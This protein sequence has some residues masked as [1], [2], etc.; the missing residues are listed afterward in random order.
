MEEIKT[1]E[2]TLSE[3]RITNDINNIRNDAT[4][5]EGEKKKMDT[6]DI[7]SSSGILI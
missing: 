3:F 4:N 6:P 5:L 7:N 1:M 2:K